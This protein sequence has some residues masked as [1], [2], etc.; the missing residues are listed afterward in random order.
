M[1][2]LFILVLTFLLGYSNLGAQW[3]ASNGKPIGG[4]TKG[5]VFGYNSFFKSII[6]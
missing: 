4:Q 3:E 5:V 1:K 2:W 6:I